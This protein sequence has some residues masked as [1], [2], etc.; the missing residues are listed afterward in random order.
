MVVPGLTSENLQKDKCSGGGLYEGVLIVE[1]IP[2]ICFLRVSFSAHL[3]VVKFLG[4]RLSVRNVWENDFR[5]LNINACILEFIWSE[6]LVPYTF[7][8]FSCHEFIHCFAHQINSAIAKM[9][10]GVWSL[11]IWR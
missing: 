2:I 3:R 5:L 7:A 10:G 11:L 9:E 6:L 1:D 4:C 8:F